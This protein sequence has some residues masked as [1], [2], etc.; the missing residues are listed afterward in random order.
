MHTK[1]E[2][3][4]YTTFVL[5]LTKSVNRLAFLS[6][7]LMFIVGSIVLIGGKLVESNLEQSKDSTNLRE[8][9]ISLLATT[10][11]MRRREKDFFLRKDSTYSDKYYQLSNSAFKIVEKL[12]A[13]KE[14][15]KYYK[16]LTEL[17]E[18]LQLHNQQFGLSVLIL[19]NLGINSAKGLQGE[20]NKTGT[21]IDQILNQIKPDQKTYSAW[22]AMQMVYLNYIIDGTLKDK[23]A[24]KQTT[25]HLKS[26]LTSDKRNPKLNNQAMLFVDKY[27][28]QFQNVIIQ[29]RASVVAQEKLTTIF[30]NFEVGIENLIDFT[31]VTSLDHFDRVKDSI[32][33]WTIMV[34]FLNLITA[35]L[36]GFIAVTI[37]RRISK[38][39]RR[40]DKD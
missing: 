23:N 31:R 4:P 5:W 15:D 11:E 1:N 10:Q 8:A 7:I 37:I 21:A 28:F 20:L 30:H 13:M 22:Q 18:H 3:N 40:L 9:T 34:T 33:Y 38:Y 16:I 27:A 35:L 17:G 25:D 26:L 12:K 19:Q 39:R 29:Q 14:G 6:I 36:V 32:Q 24:I 2:Q